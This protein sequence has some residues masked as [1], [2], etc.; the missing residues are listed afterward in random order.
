MRLPDIV[1]LTAAVAIVGSNSLALSPIAVSVAGDFPGAAA[2][3]VMMASALFGA[4]TA[5]SA[6]TLAPAVDRIGLSR[7]LVLALAV[8]ATA[9]AATALAPVLWHFVAAQTFA[10]LATGV[11]LPATY[12]LATEKAPPGQASSYLG[13]VLTGWTL[14]MVFGAS[15]AAVL[16]E[17]AGWRVVYG[18]LA[19]VGFL[20]L[21]ACIAQ[22]FW[23][24]PALRV[25]G[26]TPLAALKVPGIVP[27]LMVCGVYMM[28]FYGLYAYLG[29]HLRST[30]G[31]ATW[32]A[33]LAPLVYGLGFGAAAWVDPVID[34]YGMRRVA[35]VVFT[36]L[37]GV[38]GLLAAVSGQAALLIGMCLLWGG[39]N[40]LSLNMIVSRLAALDPARR[41]AI[42]GLN[43]GMT[44]ISVFLG[45]ALF[46]AVFERLGFVACAL[47]SAACILPAMAEAWKL[48]LGR[49]S[50]AGSSL[51]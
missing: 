34:R 16:T 40:H 45:T 31:V 30:L 1:L 4:G 32:V 20:T 9:M 22:G 41:G 25:T 27:A 36:I 12:G 35:P 51:R 39:V 6:L 11:A 23:A 44:Y 10:G 49:A 3:D 29:T 2:A 19:G 18:V 33:G 43:S 26:L 21:A 5:L 28:A 24:K 42:L 17:V 46:G 38:Y 15:A 8:L 14:S 48:R 37:V 13:R 7:A 47:L 50:V